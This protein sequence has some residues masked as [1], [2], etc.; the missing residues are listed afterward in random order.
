[1]G[2]PLEPPALE[3][4]VSTGDP[5][6]DTQDYEILAGDTYIAVVRLDPSAGK[7]I[8]SVNTGSQ[9]YDLSDLIAALMHA[10]QRLLRSEIPGRGSLLY[11]EHV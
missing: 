4:V 2:L 6:L 1:M 8:A 3:I 5:E 11:D 10:Q 9:F 7:I